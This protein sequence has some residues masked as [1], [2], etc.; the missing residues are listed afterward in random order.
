MCQ[1]LLKSNLCL[2]A[3]SLGWKKQRQQRQHAEVAAAAQIH[4]M[5][6]RIMAAVALACSQI[7]QHRKRERGPSGPCTAE[8]TAQNAGT[9]LAYLE[10]LRV[11]PHRPQCQTASLSGQMQCPKAPN[12][13]P[14]LARNGSVQTLER[15]YSCS[16][17]GKGHEDCNGTHLQCL[18]KPCLL[19]AQCSPIRLPKT[20]A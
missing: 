3:V 18:E 9:L 19:Y 15:H 13:L 16:G 11:L 1:N 7:T 14:S 12:S 5:Q 17:S 4:R 10:A 8:D 2:Q 6:R 20:A